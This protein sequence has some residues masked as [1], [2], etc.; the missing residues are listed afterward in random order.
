MAKKI[1]TT[2]PKKDFNFKDLTT[3]EDFFKIQNIPLDARPD[4]SKVPEE[5]RAPL[6]AIYD[7]M[8][9]F[10][11]VKNGKKIDWADGKNKYCAWPW[12]DADKDRPSGFRFNYSGYHCTDSHS[13]VGSRLSSYEI[14]HVLH[15]FKY[16]NKQYEHFFFE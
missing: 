2:E 13:T 7:L 3:V 14:D 8:V 5:F 1:K 15:I 10:K 16:L 11:A 12:I 4:L 6:D 9:A